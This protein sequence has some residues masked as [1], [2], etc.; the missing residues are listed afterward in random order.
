M[1]RE[2]KPISD[3]TLVSKSEK[4][5]IQTNSNLKNKPIVNLKDR[6]QNHNSP[7]IRL[8]QSKIESLIALKVEMDDVLN[9]TQQKLILKER[10]CLDLHNQLNKR[11]NYEPSADVSKF[12]SVDSISS[13]KIS[14][15]HSVIKSEDLLT[16][17]DLEIK[18]NQ[19][20]DKCSKLESELKLVK[21]SIPIYQKINSSLTDMLLHEQSKGLVLTSSLQNLQIEDLKRFIFQTEREIRELNKQ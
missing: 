16:L 18:I 4:E 8:M 13:N 3:L 12:I 1:V 17:N 21:L 7:S 2:L 6:N 20:Q 15:N 5:K 14:F 9:T 19:Y 11:F 10:E